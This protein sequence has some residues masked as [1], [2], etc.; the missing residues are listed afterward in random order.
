MT[1]DSGKC[2]AVVA[3][4]HGWGSTEGLTEMVGEAMRSGGAAGSSTATAGRP[5]AQLVLS[6]VS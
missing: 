1:C 2:A 6:A 3:H 5:H 4:W